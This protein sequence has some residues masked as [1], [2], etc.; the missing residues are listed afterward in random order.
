MQNEKVEGGGNAFVGNVIRHAR[1]IVSDH[2][3]R[4]HLGPQ[5]P[6]DGMMPLIPGGTHRRERSHQNDRTDAGEPCCGA[7]TRSGVACRAPAVYGKT[8]CRM[9]GGPKR[10]S[11][12]RA[13]Q[14]AR[15]RGLFSRDAIAERRRI[16]ALLREAWRLLEG[17]K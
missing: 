8:R 17:T 15:K 10:S 9:L 16:C 4:G 13:N 7:R 6:G 2:P 11:P 5:A 12:P 1:V 14:N 3:R